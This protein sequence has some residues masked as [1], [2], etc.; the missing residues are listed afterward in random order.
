MKKTVRY[1]ISLMMILLMVAASSLAVCAEDGTYSGST[2]EFTVEGMF[3]DVSNMMPGDTASQDVGIRVA[4][5]SGN[6]TNIY[7]RAEA[8]GDSAMLEG[9]T[10]TVKQ[11]SRTLYTGPASDFSSNVLIGKFTTGGTARITVDLSLPT[12]LG[13]EAADSQTTINWI[14]TAEEIPNDDGGGNGGNGGG[15]GGN[16][17]AGDGDGTVP[18]ITPDTDTIDDG[19]TPMAD[20]TEID[21]E[22]VPQA[23]G[24]NAWAL[25]NLIS[26]AV[27]VIGAAAALFRKKENDYA[28]GFESEETGNRGARMAAAKAAGAL[29][30]VASVIT[31]IVTENMSGSMVLVDRWTVLMIAILAVQVVSAVLNKKAS[32][33]GGGAEG[34]AA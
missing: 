7:L 23:G 29:A 27:T 10:L 1:L 30:A 24:Q 8:S 34:E 20:F 5:A 16:Q 3:S 21:D 6:T 25:I 2:K 14:L 22:E 33:S 11:G 15:G 32:G 13:N 26:A 18:E 4:P 28:D 19:D 12:S 17:N 9:S 31:F